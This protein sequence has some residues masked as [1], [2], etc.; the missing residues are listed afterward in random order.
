MASISAGIPIAYRQS[1]WGRYDRALKNCFTGAGIL[2]LATLISIYLVPK[3][4]AVDLQLEQVPER[5]AKLIL[6]KPKA[7]PAPPRALEKLA[8]LES[9]PK[10][11]PAPV[12]KV[13]PVPSSRRPV[14]RHTIVPEADPQAGRKGR[15]KATVEVTQNL[16]EVQSSLDEAL[17]QLSAS[18]PASQTGASKSGSQH[19][20]SH[21]VRSGR[22]LGQLASVSGVE[23]TK[24][25][26]VGG[27]GLKSNGISIASI[28]QLSGDGASSE[29]SE[30]GSFEGGSQGGGGELRSTASLLAVVRRYAAGIQFCYDNQLKKRPG[31]RGKL[32]V[33]LVVAA[34]GSVDAAQVVQNDL[35]DQE[36][37]DCVLAQIRAWRFPAIPKGSVSF[38]TPFVFTPPE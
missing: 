28:A 11:E 16:K 27:G 34:D 8:K 24:G 37:V 20:R 9:E 23:V 36:V 30:G 25:K 5:F 6:E 19:R 21:R 38:K 18:L 10:E 17:D 15:E 1:I 7:P 31:L 4:A 32:V 22:D 2:G 26:A 29:G 12:K 14:E 13:Q 35:H 33:S 3:P